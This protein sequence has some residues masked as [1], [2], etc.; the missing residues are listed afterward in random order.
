CD[1]ESLPRA[2]HGSLPPRADAP[3]DT[4]SHRR[5]CRF[6]PPGVYPPSARRAPGAQCTCPP[7]ACAGAS[8][9]FRGNLLLV[10][11]EKPTVISREIVAGKQKPTFISRRIVPG[12]PNRVGPVEPCRARRTALLPL[13]G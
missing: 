5:C 9:R 6:P 2:G 8:A 10:F 3:T 7:G 1:H 13:N 12:P 4:D 11:R